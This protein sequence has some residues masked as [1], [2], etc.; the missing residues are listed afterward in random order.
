MDIPKTSKM[1][2]VFAG[3][4]LVA[5]LYWM[6]TDFF[7]IQGGQDFDSLSY[8]ASYLLG[9]TPILFFVVSMK[10]YALQKWPLR[11]GMSFLWTLGLTFLGLVILDEF[12][13]V[14]HL[15]MGGSF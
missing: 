9:L 5:F 14:V 4:M 12:A 10:F 13:E 2:L 7:W 11:L 1:V 8:K 3:I 6:V 15:A